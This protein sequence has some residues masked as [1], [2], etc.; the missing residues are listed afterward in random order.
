MQHGFIQYLQWAKPWTEKGSEDVIKDAE[1]IS[2]LQEGV[3]GRWVQEL[4]L[5]ERNPP[6]P[7]GSN[8]SE[9]VLNH[10]KNQG[11]HNPCT[12]LL[13]LINVLLGI[14]Q[15][16]SPRGFHQVLNVPKAQSLWKPSSFT[17][18][19]SIHNSIPFLIPSDLNPLLK[20]TNLPES[21]G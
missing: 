8:Q 3:G 12:S 19:L 18:H 10:S 5:G 20:N 9:M 13:C 1:L 15:S 2:R 21:A 7:S 4:I 17:V 6:S 14:R 16:K 11:L